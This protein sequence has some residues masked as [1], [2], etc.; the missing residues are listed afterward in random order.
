MIITPEEQQK[1]GPLIKASLPVIGSL[2]SD[3]VNTFSSHRAHESKI[4][5]SGLQFMLE[6]YKN[7][8]IST[9]ATTSKESQKSETLKIC[10]KEFC[11]AEDPLSEAANLPVSHWWFH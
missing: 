3:C 11:E 2:V 4:L 9:P 8:L 7:F 10:F 1:I 6:D 5:R